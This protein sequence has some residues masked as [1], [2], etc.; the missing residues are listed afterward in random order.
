VSCGMCDSACPQGLP[1][2]SLFASA[3]S[4][5]Q[6]M[7]EYVPGR[8]AGEEPPVSVFKEEELDGEAGCGEHNKESG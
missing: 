2:S 3:G 8:D 1:V 4:E 5:L 6:Q 7:F